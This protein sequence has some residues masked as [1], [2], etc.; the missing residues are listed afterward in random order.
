MKILDTIAFPPMIRVRQK[1]KPERLT[2]VAGAISAKIKAIAPELPIRPGQSVALAC[3]SRGLADYPAIL[4]S[5]VDA[6][7]ELRL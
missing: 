4:K 2:D 5:V 6:L 3:P 1:L 7:K